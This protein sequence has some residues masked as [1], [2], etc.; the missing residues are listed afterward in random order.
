MSKEDMSRKDKIV[1]T[2]YDT[3]T[4]SIT[5]WGNDFIS[6]N[7]PKAMNW[8]VEKIKEMVSSLADNSNVKSRGFI[9]NII[10]RGIEIG[11]DNK[12]HAMILAMQELEIDE[13]QI[14]QILIASKQYLIT[15]DEIDKE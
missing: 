6:T 4:D 9:R 10:Y 12:E 8:T 5:K 13:K 3:G 7:V 1:N 11:E 15:I 2:F 14:Q